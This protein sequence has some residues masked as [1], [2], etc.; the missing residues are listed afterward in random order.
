[1]FGA[2][3]INPDDAPVMFAETPENLQHYM[4]PKWHMKLQAREPKDKSSYL[5][6]HY[7]H[8]GRA[9]L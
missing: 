3:V 5:C 7:Q 2:K 1:M 6:R 9:N 8:G 4:K